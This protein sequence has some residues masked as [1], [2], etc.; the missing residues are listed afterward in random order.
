MELWELTSSVKCMLPWDQALSNGMILWCMCGL[1]HLLLHDTYLVFDV[2]H[3][4]DPRIIPPHCRRSANT[5]LKI[6]KSLPAGDVQQIMSLNYVCRKENSLTNPTS[7][8]NQLDE[9]DALSITIPARNTATNL[10]EWNLKLQEWSTSENESEFYMPTSG[11]TSSFA[12]SHAAFLGT[13][14]AAW[15]GWVLAVIFGKGSKCN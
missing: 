8:Q 14:L 7:N 11:S 12:T 13:R 4:K 9:T 1:L 6:S 3:L 5:R 10:F 15:D 2:L